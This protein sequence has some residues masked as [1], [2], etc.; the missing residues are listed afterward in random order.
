VLGF[1]LGFD[2][3]RDDGTFEVC[4]PSHYVRLGRQEAGH[5]LG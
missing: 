3:D 2:M 5:R 1:V 4:W